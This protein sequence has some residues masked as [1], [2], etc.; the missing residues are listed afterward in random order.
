[1][2]YLGLDYGERKVGLAVG[3][4]QTRL[5]VPLETIRF[6]SIDKLLEK[7][8]KVSKETEVSKVVIGIS[9]GK[10]AEKTKTFAKTLQEKLKIPVIFQ[11]ETLTTKD[12]QRLS[13]EAGIKRNKRKS[14]EDAYS[15][16]LILQAHL[17][18]I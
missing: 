9:E 2:K 15:A 12:A 3:D 18:T 8:S 1:M 14:L 6:S 7:V 13:I 17:D 5:A 11:D 10:M 16:A 4:D